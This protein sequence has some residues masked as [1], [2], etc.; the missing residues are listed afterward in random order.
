MRRDDGDGTNMAEGDVHV[1][2]INDLREHERTRDCWCHPDCTREP[3]EE[4]PVI[5]TH[6]SLDGR[7]LIEEHGLN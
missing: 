3:Y 2:P 4:G 6:Q 1:L 5:V 7:E